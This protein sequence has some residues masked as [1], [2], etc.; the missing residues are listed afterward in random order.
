MEQWMNPF[1][2][3]EWCG[4]RARWTKNRMDPTKSLKIPKID[5]PI[6]Q[7]GKIYNK[8]LKFYESGNEKL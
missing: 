8:F 6:P 3:E 4:K 7:N 1:I 2:E 5:E